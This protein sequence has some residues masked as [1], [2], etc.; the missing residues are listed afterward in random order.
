[1]SYITITQ[2]IEEAVKII[3]EGRVAAVPTGTSYG[4]AVD[5]LQGHALQR[6]RNMKERPEGKTFTVF[7]RD[8]LWDKFLQLTVQETKLLTAMA[9]QAL[10]LL[11]KP[12]K[13]LEHLAQDGLIGLRVIDHPLMAELA[14]AVEV[15]LT[16]TSANKAGQ[17]PCRTPLCIEEVWPGKLDE[18]TYDLSL[19]VI[20]DG[21]ELPSGKVSTVARL[22]DGAV[23]IVRE[24]AVSK[25]ELEEKL[26]L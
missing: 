2:E 4:L 26:A 12:T 8:E 3:L 14:Q 15:P 17:E 16:A 19:A 24:G 10:T 22:R 1:M 21:G 20:L 18:T 9:G 6:L 11:V 5:A 25:T 13:G 23:E 7:M